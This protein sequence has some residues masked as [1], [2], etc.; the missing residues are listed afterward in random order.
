MSLP[1]AF[2]GLNMPAISVIIL[3]Y[4]GRRLLKECLDSLRAQTF[5]DFEVIFVDNGSTDGSAALVA[6]D[7]PEVRIVQNTE[8]LGFGEGNNVGIRLAAGKYTA[9]LNNDTATHPE[10]LQRLFE[11][12]ERSP[13]D[14]GMW[15]SKILFYDHPDIIDTAG[16]LM[17]PDGQNIGRGRGEHDHGQYDREEEVFF[18][19][20]CAALYLKKMLDDIGHFDPDFFAYADDTELGLRARLAGWKCLFVPSS[21]VYHKYSA[22]SGRYS[23]FKVFLVERNRIWAL[24]KYFP[25][26]YIILSPFYTIVRLGGHLAAAFQ[27]RGAAGRFKES[28]SMAALARVYLRANIG[29]VLGL[30]KML[31]KRRQ[32]KPIRRASVKEFSGWLRRFSISAREMA[33]KE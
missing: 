19:S 17:Y 18:P 26:R 21:V 11:T 2:S 27:R 8:N 24:V 30:G 16:H 25:L 33:L 14:V 7:Y 20:G 12:A 22:T 13:E 3:N 23:R 32:M 31:K 29:A 5:R 10:W 15:A 28:F 6:A 9:L 4:N 1:N